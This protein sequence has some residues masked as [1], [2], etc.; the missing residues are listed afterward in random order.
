MWQHTSILKPKKRSH[1]SWRDH[2][3][4]DDECKITG[5]VN[6]SPS[7]FSQGHEGLG[8]SLHASSDIQHQDNANYLTNIV[9]INTLLAAIYSIIQPDMFESG[10]T[11]FEELIEHAE[12]LN[13]PI[14]KALLVWAT[15]FTG[16]SVIL[17]RETITHRDVK[18][19]RES[20]DL[21]LTIGDYTGGRLHLP[22]LGFSLIYD[23]GTVV[24]L[25]G[26]V[27]QHG[28]CPVAGDRACLAHFWHQKVGERLG[29]RQPGWVTMDDLTGNI[30]G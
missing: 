23:P 3:H 18:G 2:I 10:I 11:I 1:G 9:F 20:F 7:W 27:L 29:V 4:P 19:Y 5:I 15:P 17:N 30:I 24:A 12:E 8:E 13:K 26:N 22:G 21:L 25:A 16:L 6:L 14:S 28:V